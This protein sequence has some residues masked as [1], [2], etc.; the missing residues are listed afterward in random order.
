[1]KIIVSDSGPIIHLYEANLLYL[2]QT[3]GKIYVPYKVL[4]EIESY[5]SIKLT[6]KF[7][8]L[9]VL[10]LTEEEIGEKQKLVHLNLLQKA[11]RK[12]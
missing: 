12:R 3:I 10:S 6:E 1:M 4:N 5:L 2:L 11:N 8:Y 9:E 7:E